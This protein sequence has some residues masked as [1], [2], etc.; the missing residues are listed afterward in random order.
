MTSYT[1]QSLEP[2]E[3]LS[4]EDDQAED[5]NTTATADSDVVVQTPQSSPLMALQPDPSFT[6]SRSGVY[7]STLMS[8][9]RAGPD[10]ITEDKPR[11]LYDLEVR[12]QQEAMAQPSSTA[13]SYSPRQGM[14]MQNKAIDILEEKQHDWRDGETMPDKSIRDASQHRQPNQPWSE[15]QQRGLVSSGRGLQESYTPNQQHDLNSI[16][17]PPM[18]ATPVSMEFRNTLAKVPPWIYSK[19]RTHTRVTAFHGS[20]G[21]MGSKFVLRQRQHVPPQKTRFQITINATG[22]DITGFALTWNSVVDWL[23]DLRDPFSNVIDEDFGHASQSLKNL[24]W[25]EIAIFIYVG[26][27]AESYDKYAMP[28]LGA[29]AKMGIHHDVKDKLSSENMSPR[30]YLYEVCNSLHF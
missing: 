18:V 28:I 26:T 23:K 9:Q 27:Y 12:E 10:Q 2:V 7:T 14:T 22:W 24:S 8:S 21:W 30:A 5:S 29:L 17:Q 16:S 25:Q 4:L 11:Q 1:E 20:P 3:D 6:T 15:P 19:D 13:F